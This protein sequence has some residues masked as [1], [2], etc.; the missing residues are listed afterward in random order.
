MFIEYGYHRGFTVEEI[1]QHEITNFAYFLIDKDGYM[2]KSAKAQLGTE[3]L[4]L[5]PLID[6]KGPETVPQTHAIIIDF[7]A[8]VRKVPLKKLHPPVKTF[9]DFVVALTSIVVQAGHNSDEIHMR[10]VKGNGCP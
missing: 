7:M 4:K 2:R 6:R 10:E 8:L 9:H 5:Y 1:L 3:L